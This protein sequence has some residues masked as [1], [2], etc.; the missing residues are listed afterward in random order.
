MNLIKKKI[1]EVFFEDMLQSFYY[2][3]LRN[4]ITDNELKRDLYNIYSILIKNNL[5]K[6]TK[7]KITFVYNKLSGIQKKIDEMVRKE[8]DEEIKK[9]I[10]KI[11]LKKNK[12]QKNIE[13]LTKHGKLAAEVSN[14][15][16]N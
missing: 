5:S 6:E 16:F 3:G 7:N 9:N 12:T 13:Y 15:I 4:N 2:K 11:F 8:K 10:R 14:D 1:A